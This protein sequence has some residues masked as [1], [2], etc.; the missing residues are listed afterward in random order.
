MAV[1]DKSGR[2]RIEA[3]VVRFT[4]LAGTKHEIPT[5]VFGHRLMTKK[6]FLKTDLT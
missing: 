1:E 4:E 3:I 6:T 5:L 2:M